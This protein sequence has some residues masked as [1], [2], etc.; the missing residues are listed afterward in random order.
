MSYEFYNVAHV[1]GVLFLFTAL[2][3]LAATAGSPSAPLRKIA[4]IAHG[5]ALALIFVAGFGL[6]ARLGYFGSIPAWAYFKMVLWGVLGL[7]VLPLK[8]KPQWAPALWVLM[9]IVGSLAV[10]AAV[11]QPFG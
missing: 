4:S 10:W 6:L 9:P 8:K 7:A 1:I 2:G 11:V 3:A 5:V